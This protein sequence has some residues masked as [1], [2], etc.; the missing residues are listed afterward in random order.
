M[1]QPSCSL[2]SLCFPLPF[3]WLLTDLSL[4]V[5]FVFFPLDVL[6]VS[7][8][9]CPLILCTCSSSFLFFCT[10]RSDLVFASRVSLKFGCCWVLWLSLSLSFFS[11]RSPLAQIQMPTG[12]FSHLMFLRFFPF[13]VFFPVVFFPLVAWIR[14]HGCLPIRGCTLVFTCIVRTHSGH[15]YEYSVA[16]ATVLPLMDFVL[17]LSFLSCSKPDDEN[18]L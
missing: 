1:S 18:A 4:S 3:F 14:S 9:A 17:D 5:L 16:C 6:L 12:C 7:F 2:P 15:R 11:H 10:E 13:L 8:L